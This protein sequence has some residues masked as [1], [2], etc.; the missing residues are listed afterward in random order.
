MRDNNIESSAK[1]IT[2]EDG[3]AKIDLTV[4]LG[5]FI[6]GFRRFW[7]LIVVGALLFGTLFYGKAVLSYTP[8]YCSEATFTVSVDDS[9][10]NHSFY[11]NS[12]TAEQLGLTFPHILSS[13]I[14]QDAM[15]NDMGVDWINGRVEMK[16][17]ANS[18][19][20]TMYAYSSN[21]KDAKRVLE[22]AIKVYPDVARY[23]IGN[24]SFNMIDNPTLPT[25]PCNQADYRDS[26][27]KGAVIGLALG[28]IIIA[29]YAFFRKTIHTTEEID[30][31]IN[32]TNMV[33][34][35]IIKRKK[36]SSKETYFPTIYERGINPVFA[37][38]IE[39]LRIRVENE[40]AKDNKKV[41]MV[42]STV[43]GEGKS[44]VSAN[45]AYV[46]GKHDKKVLLVDGDFRKQDL[47]SRLSLK[48]YTDFEHFDLNKIG[49]DDSIYI[50]DEKRKIFF[51]GGNAPV[52]DTSYFLPNKLTK[53]I[54]KARDY[55]DYIV[56][57]T[58]PA[59]DFEDSL[60]TNSCTDAI[61]YVVKQDYAPKTKVLETMTMLH[62]DNVTENEDSK[63]I[64]YVFNGVTG[65]LGEY[66]YNK[67]A[68]YGYGYGSS[69]G[70]G[71][72]KKYGGYGSA[73][74][75]KP[76]AEKK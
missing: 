7:W 17:V 13:E 18:N 36:R 39:S 72:G 4:L 64:G 19:M 51:L 41:L 16:T 34:L 66:D 37:E 75:E 33:S 14:L 57:D 67:Y 6:K 30:N 58:P 31:T 65:M 35:P 55:F 26:F 53:I 1:N 8:S 9:T 12:A 15:K 38:T 71:Y 22:S 70:Y 2:A 23:V 20:V 44:L 62:L 40:L 42:T 63:I 49:K 69:Y 29:F 56:I 3:I 28:V 25:E 47:A 74:G 46:L 52:E 54:D 24:I 43:P 11:Y 10:H 50:R 32:V 27:T 68:K 76:K 59:G 45:L 73:Y 5:D 21:P 61:L 48:E 60:V